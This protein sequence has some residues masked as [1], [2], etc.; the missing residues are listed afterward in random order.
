MVDLVARHEWQVVCEEATVKEESS[1]ANLV[2]Q[3]LQIL[4][5]ENVEVRVQKWAGMVMDSTGL[6]LW[7][8]TLL[9]GRTSR[10]SNGT[11]SATPQ[12]G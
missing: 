9:L 5:A 7:R 10:C 2:D 8:G 3:W 12:Q 4:I 1:L 6:D 11:G